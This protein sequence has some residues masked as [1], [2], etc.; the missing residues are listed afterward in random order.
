MASLDTEVAEVAEVGRGR[1][2]LAGSEP[3]G[4]EAWRD[5]EADERETVLCLAR[6]VPL[7][8]QAP[9]EGADAVPVPCLARLLLAAGGAGKEFRRAKLLLEPGADRSRVRLALEPG[10]E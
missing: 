5:S 3:S 7:P 4:S 9:P 2:A 1:R 8:A 6:R 10:A